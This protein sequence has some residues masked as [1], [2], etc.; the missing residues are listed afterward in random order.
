MTKRIGIIGG[1]VTGLSAAHFLEKETPERL[2]IELFEAA[3][4]PGGMI[5][6]SRFRTVPI[7]F[8]AGAAELYDIPHTPLLRRT[9][10]DLGLPTVPLRGSP[11]LVLD[12]RVL[13]SLGD[14]AEAFGAP[15]ARAVEAF[16]DLGRSLRTPEQ[17][18]RAGWPADEEH[19]WMRRS[20][21][22]VLADV[23]DEAARRY[24]AVQCHSDLAAEP[25]DT[26]GLFGFDN[27]LIDD[28]DYCRLYA[29]KGGNEQLVSALR[30][31]LEA[32]VHLR[33]PVTAAWKNPDG[34]YGLRVRRPGGTDEH[35][36][37]ALVC[38]LPH[39][40]LR[41]V[42]WQG[43]GLAAAMA[44]HHRHYDFPT[45][46][47]RVTLLFREPFWREVFDESYFVTDAFG[48]VCVYDESSR[49][50]AKGYGVLS[51][52][53]GGRPAFRWHLWCDAVIVRAALKALPPQVARG[54]SSFVEGRVNRW[55]RGVSRRP[56]GRHLKGVWERHLPAPATHPG[57]LAAGDYHF[58]ST[59]NGALDSSRMAAKMALVHLGLREESDWPGDDFDDEVRWGSLAG[60]AGSSA[61]RL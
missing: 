23:P 28:P 6:T 34:T 24:L 38:A 9:V 37:D 57:L 31:S 16:Y 44:A 10:R 43:G 52:L 48:G 58:D 60:R 47:L 27:L 29:I 15:A 41:T 8:E 59:I 55:I 13:R 7:P 5:R 39:R 30:D 53:L 2:S 32:R 22:S 20:F 17:Y 54:R 33:A 25:E 42:S 61:Q 49:F 45:H 1:G 35:A 36:F 26:H 11:T 12:G 51:F 18:A 3:D 46:Y 56:G 50:D 19:P 14:F 21:A 4:R 40:R